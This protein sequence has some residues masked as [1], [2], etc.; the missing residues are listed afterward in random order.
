MWRLWFAIG[1]IGWAVTIF[2][3][4]AMNYLS[5]YGFGRTTE[6]SFVFAL[7]GVAADAG[8]SLGPIFI[9]SLYR[10]GQRVTTM[11]ALV[12]WVLCFAVA[13]TAAIGLVAKNRSAMTGKQD[14]LTASYELR[15]SELKDLLAQR[16]SIEGKRSAS[17][18]NAAIMVALARP[19]S[20]GK[21]VRG[22]VASLSDRCEHT[23]T[24]TAS[25][26]ADVAALRQELAAAG[27]AEAMTARI[28]SL[29]SELLQLEQSGA[30]LL[31]DPQADLLSRLS[32]GHIA[33]ADVPT[34]VVMLIVMMVE[35]VSAFT[36]MVLTEYA[37]SATFARELTTVATR[38]GQSGHDSTRT[39][40]IELR[41]I[42]EVFDYMADRI[43]PAATGSIRQRRLFDDYSNWCA[44]MT[45]AALQ[46]RSFVAEFERICRED[47][48]ERVRIIGDRYLGCTFADEPVEVA[49][50]QRGRLRIGRL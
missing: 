48:A 18:I 1:W 27:N 24:L 44:G 12:V 34:V 22:T 49:D 19:V 50:N 38:R 47:L 20:I 46:R 9:V 17:E 41:P 30:S 4:G 36:P 37:R 43:R 40:S 23:D 6:E 3:S 39:S 16:G 32:L 5:G 13:V 8:K 2:A 28:Q 21:R 15:T 14:A 10:G 33:A 11:L 31:A 35:M 25:A 45:R 26:C 7:L 29:R 42:G